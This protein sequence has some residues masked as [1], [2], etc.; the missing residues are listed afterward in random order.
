[1]SNPTYATPPMRN[2]EV[3]CFQASPKPLPGDAILNVLKRGMPHATLNMLISEVVNCMTDL[4][5]YSRENG[6]GATEAFPPPP[7]HTGENSSAHVQLQEQF[8]Q[9][10]E[11]D[12]ESMSS[13]EKIIREVM[14]LPRFSGMGSTAGVVSVQNNQQNTKGI[15]QLSSDSPSS[16]T[17]NN[18]KMDRQ[19]QFSNWMLSNGNSLTSRL[20]GAWSRPIAS[21]FILAS[22]IVTCTGY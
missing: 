16:G 17:T 12:L 22:L 3:F 1:M 13:V 10:N 19:L 15:T 18:N 11:A 6:T 9:S 20:I 21:P 7:P 8:S 4:I 14:A 5:D 2:I